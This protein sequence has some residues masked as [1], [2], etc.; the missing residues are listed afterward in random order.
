M[1]R[2]LVVQ[3][4]VTTRQLILSYNRSLTVCCILL[5]HPYFIVLLFTRGRRRDLRLRVYRLEIFEGTRIVQNLVILTTTTNPTKSLVVLDI[6][7]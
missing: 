2:Y 5:F 1:F 6:L 3:N 7:T 4:Y